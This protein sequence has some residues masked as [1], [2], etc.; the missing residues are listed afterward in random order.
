MRVVC[1]HEKPTAKPLPVVVWIHIVTSGR[2]DFVLLVSWV[3]TVLYIC[4]ATVWF[5]TILILMSNR[6]KFMDRYPLRI[7]YDAQKKENSLTKSENPWAHGMARSRIKRSKRVL[8]LCP[9]VN[10][11]PRHW[12]N[13]Y[14]GREYY[15][16]SVWN[17]ELSFVDYLWRPWDCVRWPKS[18]TSMACTA[19]F[20]RGG[21]Q[22]RRWWAWLR[23]PP[24]HKPLASTV[25]IFEPSVLYFKPTPAAADGARGKRS[26]E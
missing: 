19:S 7:E 15:S 6:L 25:I 4:V 12:R 8:I 22:M 17:I 16:V 14:L 2:F 11:S 13:W 1:I 10:K 18:V 5:W 3:T 23:W 9:A 21:I 24:F 20:K 26:N